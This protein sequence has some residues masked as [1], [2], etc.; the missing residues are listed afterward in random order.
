[1]IETSLISNTYTNML[2]HG[3]CINWSPKLLTTYVISNALIAI[4]YYS[5]PIALIYLA[6]KR[7]DIQFRGALLLFAAF[8]FACGTTHLMSIVLIWNPIYWLDASIMAFTAAISIISAVYL[9]PLIPKLVKLPSPE[10]LQTLNKALAESEERFRC[11]F[12]TAAIGMALVSLSGGWIKVNS[13][14]LQMLGYS[15]SELHNTTFQEITHPDDLQADLEYVKRLISGEINSYQMEK[16]YFHKDER[17][18]WVL[19][20]VS[21]V[22]DTANTPIHFVAQ[23][24][25][26]TERR[27]ARESALQRANHDVLTGLP[28]RRLLEDRMSLALHQA[29]RYQRLMAVMFIDI[30][31]FKT[32]NDTFGHDAGDLL[33]KTVAAKLTASVR[34]VDTICRLGGD[35]FVIVLTEISKPEDA[36]LVAKT[37][38]N[39]LTQPLMIQTQNIQIGLSIGIAVYYPTSN[40]N[41]SEL[42]KKA[43]IA[44]YQVKQAGRNSY[45]I[46]IDEQAG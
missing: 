38:L 8:I 15:E 41:E 11:S 6:K 18:I 3:F 25:D 10:Q 23:I 29:M 19:L 26:I 35:E 24:E 39:S 37:I 42:M 32:I 46:F 13:S 5:I 9:W 2:P 12:E 36:S 44:L 40:D 34:D 1:M 7:P 21:L 16:R 28:N 4:S 33:L 31:N 14:L 20:S 27:E 17:V 22:R 30:D 45:Q 43:D